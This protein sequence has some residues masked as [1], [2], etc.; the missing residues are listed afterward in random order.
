VIDAHCHIWR[1]ARGDYGWLTPALGPIHRDVAITDWRRLAE[2]CGVAGGIL[3]QAAASEAETRFLLDAAAA[4][5]DSPVLGVVGWVDLAAIDAPVRVARIAAEPLVRGLRPMLQDIADPD[6]ILD[7]SVEPG[8]AAMAAHGLAF[9][10]LVRPFHL[11]RVRALA[12]RLPELTIIIDH[13]A[14]PDIA[15]GGFASW[16]AEIERIARDGRAFCK[17][18]GLITEAGA[19]PERVPRYIA[20]LLA[21]FGPDRLIWGSDWPVLELA[22]S[23]EGWHAMANAAVPPADRAAVFGLNARRAYRLA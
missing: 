20:H 10:A 6:W 16:A 21:C 4:E 9:D 8:L 13:G 18:S 14:K 1:P 2:P 17:L 19:T 11:P 7:P 5:P 15:G 3:V 12:D 22:G 23:Y